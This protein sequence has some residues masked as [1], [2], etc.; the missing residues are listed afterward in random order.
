MCY[1]LLL[2]F[3]YNG[4]LVQVN[5]F[6]FKKGVGQY[7][8]QFIKEE[9]ITCNLL[10]SYFLFDRVPNKFC[11]KAIGLGEALER[12]LMLCCSCSSVG[13]AQPW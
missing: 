8:L 10:T 2:L 13:R 12:L 3:S 11:L 1:F 6:F 4:F 5:P 9:N 7:F